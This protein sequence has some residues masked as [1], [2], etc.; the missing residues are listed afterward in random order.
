MTNTNYLRERVWNHFTSSTPE[1]IATFKTMLSTDLQLEKAVAAPVT[2]QPVVHFSEFNDAHLAAAKAV[3]TE[4]FRIANDATKSDAEA[5]G[6]AFNYLAELRQNPDLKNYALMVFITHNERGKRILQGTIPG[7]STREPQKVLPSGDQA[8][9]AFAGAPGASGSGFKPGGSTDPG[10]DKLNYFREDPAFNEHHERWHV[11]YPNGGIPYLDTDG[12]TIRYRERDRHGEMFIYMHQQMIAHY[13]ANRLAHGL[14]KVIPFDFSTPIEVGYD[15]GTFVQVF[16]DSQYSPRRANWT[17]LPELYGYSVVHQ[18]LFIDRLRR[19]AA[20]GFITLDHKTIRLNADLLGLMIES[21]GGS[22]EQFGSVKTFYGNVH[23]LGHNLI[24]NVSDT[25]TE[26]PLG[27]MC[28]TATAVR[29][30]VFFRWHKQVDDFNFTWQE[31]MPPERYSDAPDVLIRAAFEHSPDI[32]ICNLADLA[33]IGKA[34]GLKEY[35][36]GQAA[37]GGSK[38]NTDYTEGTAKV[39]AP[40]G[41]SSYSLPALSEIRNFMQDAELLVPAPAAKDPALRLPYRFLNHQQYGFFIRLENLLPV[42]SKVTVRMFMAPA[43]EA[44]NRRM[45][46]ELDKFVQDLEPFD[47]KV[48]FR[49]DTDSSIVRKPAILNPE[50]ANATIRPLAMTDIEGVFAQGLPAL[51]TALQG[52]AIEHSTDPLNAPSLNDD[53]ELYKQRI[54]SDPSPYGQSLAAGALTNIL[55]KY[56]TSFSIA[57]HELRQIKYQGLEALFKAADAAFTQ[58]VHERTLGDVTAYLSAFLD[59]INKLITL[60]QEAGKTMA[61]EINKAMLKAHDVLTD[62]AYCECGLPYNLLYPIG[63]AEGVPYVLMVMVTDWNKDITSEQTC[64]GSM[65]YCGTKGT[66][67]DIREMGY[68]FHRPFEKGVLETFAGLDNVACRSFNMKLIPQPK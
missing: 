23:N 49:R 29:D 1:Q 41:S 42:R 46:I 67:P 60:L 39:P 54:A 30:P 50:V 52:L 58:T 13:D 24:S 25:G 48:V 11:V 43:A 17:V 61:P 31:T 62:T 37:F 2:D 21:L 55:D 35:E 8:N 45:W 7:L 16:G 63:T 20:A 36:I 44:E 33:R 4:L 10:E 56:F 59:F 47:K 64:C 40:D 14:E 18:Q 12:K 34:T 22:V 51:I 28:Q 3:W 65:S 53:L 57:W 19:T 26:V 15:P 6:D 9:P 32:I 27:V 68:P 66:Y 38:W 5:V